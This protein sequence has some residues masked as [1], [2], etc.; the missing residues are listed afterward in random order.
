MH[1]AHSTY[2]IQPPVPEDR[3]YVVR[4]ARNVYSHDD[5]GPNHYIGG[6]PPEM[7]GFLD[8]PST[9][10]G[11]K[12]I[13]GVVVAGVAA[14]VVVVV[15]AVVVVA[16]SSSSPSP[17]RDFRRAYLEGHHDGVESQHHHQH[18]E[19]YTTKTLLY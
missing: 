11:C 6:R 12:A 10:K 2:I 3:H 9:N 4:R 5:E 7:D 13:A 14:V 19:D 8:L 1:R 17:Y 18:E 15:V 16:S